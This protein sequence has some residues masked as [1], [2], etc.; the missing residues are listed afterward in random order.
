MRSF[1]NRAFLGLSPSEALQLV[2]TTYCSSGFNLNLGDVDHRT[3]VSVEVSPVGANPV[4]MHGYNYHFNMYEC[5]SLCTVCSSY[6]PC[7]HNVCA[8]KCVCV[9]MCVHVWVYNVCTV[10]IFVYHVC[11]VCI[12][13]CTVCLHVCT[14]GN[15]AATCVILYMYSTV[16]WEVY[17]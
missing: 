1:L 4:Q 5:N 12:H 15:I 9:Y 13:V 10:C 2:D 11:I 7:E 17:T 3:V 8:C 14:M 6:V 16:H